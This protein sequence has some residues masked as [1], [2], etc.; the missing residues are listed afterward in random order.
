MSSYFSF[1]QQ[2]LGGVAGGV[3]RLMGRK[4][5]RMYQPPEAGPPW[6][7]AVM[8]S[9]SFAKQNSKAAERQGCRS[10]AAQGIEAEIPQKK[11]AWHLF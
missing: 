7:A 3:L 10:T 6:M 5:T 8:N 11:G 2:I 4:T 9:W 1:F